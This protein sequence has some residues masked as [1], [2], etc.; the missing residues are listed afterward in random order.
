MCL[1]VCVRRR[2]KERDRLRCVVCVC[3]CERDSDV[4]VGVCLYSESNNED[5]G[6]ILVNLD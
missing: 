5:L 3:V 2:E 4:C 1:D 6:I